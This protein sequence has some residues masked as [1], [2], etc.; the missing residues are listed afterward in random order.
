MLGELLSDG[1][2]GGHG[3]VDTADQKN[4]DV[5]ETMVAGVLL[6]ML[7]YTRRK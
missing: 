2:D 5:I 3:D 4:E 7:C 6:S 1:Q